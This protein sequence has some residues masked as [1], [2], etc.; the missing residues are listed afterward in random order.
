MKQPESFSTGFTA[1]NF[2]ASEMDSV[3]FEVDRPLLNQQ[4]VN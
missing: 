1:N 3:Q 4:R 2:H